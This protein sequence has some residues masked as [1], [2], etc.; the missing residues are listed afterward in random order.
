M[1][2]VV[3]PRLSRAMTSS[4]FAIRARAAVATA[5]TSDAG[6]T[7]TPSRSPT[8]MSPGR[9][10]VAPK[11]SGSASRPSDR[12][13]LIVPWMQT[14]AANTGSPS[15]TSRSTSRTPPSMTSPARP[16]RGRG[17]AQDLA[18][19]TPLVAAAGVDHENVAS[20]SCVEGAM[21]PKIVAGWTVDR[22]RG[23][24]DAH[25]RRDRLDPRR[26]GATAAVG[27]VNR[28][29]VDA[30]KGCSACGHSLCVVRNVA[31]PGKPYTAAGAGGSPVDREIHVPGVSQILATGGDADPV[32]DLRVAGVQ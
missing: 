8:T 22:E 24:A 17:H 18:P 7:T 25:A 5:E 21:D 32:A 31:P 15:P 4:S 30:F 14:L 9:T 28:R 13:C 16:L 29:R 2:S 19:V 6:I 27:L 11:Q 12:G 1:A 20:L 23:G 26:Q 10:S 3:S